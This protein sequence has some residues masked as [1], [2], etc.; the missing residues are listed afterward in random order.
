MHRT[1][2]NAINQNRQLCQKVLHTDVQCVAAYVLGAHFRERKK[3][4]PSV[5]NGCFRTIDSFRPRRLECT[6]NTSK[7]SDKVE[8]VNKVESQLHYLTSS[9][10]IV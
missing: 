5:S 2:E 9:E 6:H 10:L 8:D 4:L 7:K 1:S 3:E